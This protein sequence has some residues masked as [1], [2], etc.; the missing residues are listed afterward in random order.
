MRV[1][2]LSVSGG[3]FYSQEKTGSYNG[4]GWVASLQNIITTQE[5]FELGVAFLTDRFLPWQIKSGT[6]YYP[7]LSC[8]ESYFSR[9]KKY[10]GG[11]KNINT[12]EYLDEINS[13]VKDF[14]PDIIHLFGI[15]NPLSNILGNTEIPVVVHLQGILNP[16]NNAFFP[17]GFNRISFTYPFSSNEW[18]FRNGYIFAKNSM[19]VR[20]QYEKYLFGKT[21]HIM[22]RTEWDFQM[23]QLLAPEAFYFH[24][25]EALRSDFYRYAGKWQRPQGT[26]YVII[27]TI[28]ETVYKGL[29]LIMKTALLLKENTSIDFEWR[30]I[31]IKSD[32][33]IIK[34]F[35]HSTKHRSKDLNIKYLGVLSSREIC[36]QELESHVYV[37]PSYIDNSP[38]SLCEAQ[39]LGLPIIATNVGGISSL[40]K[41]NTSGIL[42]PANAPYELCYFLKQLYSNDDL[43]NRV[44]TGGAEV[45]QERHNP[46]RISKELFDCYKHIINK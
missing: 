45:A 40:V 34:F 7:I 41:N 13:I 27:S 4:Q 16:V 19:A 6:Q 5:D 20:A 39:I 42:I 30:V 18:I 35:E 8:K 21:F 36:N 38:N 44:S 3:L 31:G 37:H 11:Y 17:S 14:K 46:Q 24:V 23:S 15:E 33:K 2:W 29:D 26:K 9:L 22:G 1:L 43:C 32:S 25:D 12:R 28:S 10:Y